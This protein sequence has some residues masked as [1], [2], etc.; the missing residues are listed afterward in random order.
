MPELGGKLSNVRGTD[1]FQFG[2]SDLEFIDLEETGWLEW[3]NITLARFCECFYWKP[4]RLTCGFKTLRRFSIL[5]QGLS[6]WKRAELP[7]ARNRLPNSPLLVLP[8]SNRLE[9]ITRE[10]HKPRFISYIYFQKART[11]CVASS[12]IITVRTV[13]NRLQITSL[14]ARPSIPF[15]LNILNGF[16]NPGLV[17]M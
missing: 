13:C 8:Y 15:Y 3:Q 17:W 10:L 12:S 7:A 16:L 9:K 11:R 2:K 14:R 1:T 6:S 4:R 5:S